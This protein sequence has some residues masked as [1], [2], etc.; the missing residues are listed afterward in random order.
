MTAKIQIKRIY[1][2]A[3]ADDGFRVLVDRLWPRGISKERAA[4][5][6]WWKDIAPSPELR[7]WFGHKEERFA[8]FA[9][10][11]RTE[12]S[13]GTAAPTHMVTVNEHLAAGENVTLLYGAKDPKINQAL[14]L[15][16]WMHAMM[17]K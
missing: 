13:T 10:K 15:R 9:E 12:L 8:E 14:V 17:D 7:T 1:E 5:D 4:L 3:A 6:D 16:D 11:Y 2:A